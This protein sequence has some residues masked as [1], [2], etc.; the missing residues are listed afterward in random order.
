MA[1]AFGH[2]E[3]NQGRAAAAWD[4]AGV[5]A[6]RLAGQSC[7]VYAR[8][9]WRSPEAEQSQVG[10]GEER[11]CLSYCPA[12]LGSN[13]RKD[14]PGGALSGLGWKLAVIPLFVGANGG[15]E[16]R[17]SYVLRQPEHGLE[18][19]SRHR[20]VSE[21]SESIKNKEQRES[22]HCERSGPTS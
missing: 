11:P 7:S 6:S 17:L 13:P 22:G 18:R 19:I 15:S 5:G 21:G 2:R 1:S 8:R 12:P 9:A 14:D 10:A 20:G 3:E 4:S 16:S